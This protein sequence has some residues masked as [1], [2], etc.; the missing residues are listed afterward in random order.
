VANESRSEK[1]IRGISLIAWPSDLKHVLFDLDGTLI[2]SSRLHAK[3]FQAVIDDELPEAGGTF[4]YDDVRG[5]ATREVFRNLG[6]IDE[7]HVN[8]LTKRKQRLYQNSVE[9]GELEAMEGAIDLLTWLKANEIGVHL[10]T[11]SSR[12]SVEIALR[13]ARLDVL[14]QTVVTADDV[15]HG[16][17]DPEAYAMCL[18]L[19]QASA[20]ECLAVEDASSGIQS[21]KGADLRVVGVFDPTITDIVDEWFPDLVTFHDKLRQETGVTV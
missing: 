1:P 16:K 14:L 8:A 11:G 13:S 2:D 6:V 17:P 21:A 12:G 4:R 15:T 18:R 5:K 10:V 9:N 7:D 20:G 19:I 3:A